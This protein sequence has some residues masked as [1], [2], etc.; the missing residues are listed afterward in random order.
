LATKVGVSW[1]KTEGVLAT[2]PTLQLVV[3]PLVRRGSPI[4]DGAFAALKALGA[5]RVRY[6]PWFPYPRLVVAELDPPSPAATSWDFT[7]IDP[8]TEDFMEAAGARP[9]VLNF[10]T[11]PA[12]MFKTDM[13]VPYP[14][15]P[16]AIQWDY[17]QGSELRDPSGR[18]AGEY[19]A[20]LVSWYSNGGFT[21]ENGKAHPSGHHYDIPIWEVL[22]EADFEHGTTPQQYAE[23]YDAIVEAIHRVSPK[24]QF[25]AM[26]LGAPSDAAEF[27]E[28]FL[29]PTH[30]RPSIPIDYISYHF[31]A[32]PAALESPDTWQYTFFDQADRFISTVRFV[33]AIRKRLSPGTRTDTDE[34]GSILPGDNAVPR[35]PIPGRYWN[36]SGALFAY[37]YAN[38]AR[39]GVEVVGESQ[40]VGYPSQFPSVTMIDWTNG[41]PNARYWVLKLLID[42]LHLGDKICKT[43]ASGD[44]DVYAQGF[45]GTS[46]R[47]MLLINRRNAPA[48]V[49]L[50]LPGGRAQVVD[51]ATGE[52]PARTSTLSGTALALDPFAVAVVSWP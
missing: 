47:T 26:G 21:D 3:N 17:N 15:D 8:M 10:S 32:T 43:A 50:P 16:D 31:Y 45:T 6:V 49:E 4:H 36:A 30:H 35:V 18:E 12:W 38:L 37:V 39:M 52:E 20:R 11:I 51:E 9:T 48:R 14:K 40:L 25:M 2:T 7:L 34:I 13:P 19:F 23:R 1:E 5:D 24:T 28:Y 29:S 42:G 41:R 33:E 46:G 22:N 44:G 27:F